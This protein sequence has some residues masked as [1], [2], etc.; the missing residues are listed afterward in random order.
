M[1]KNRYDQAY[2]SFKSLSNS[3]LI[4]IGDRY[5]DKEVMDSALICYTIVSRRYDTHM[6]HED[7]KL[8]A[9]AYMR[10]GNI[11]YIMYNYVQA[12]DM[13][14]QSLEVCKECDLDSIIPRVYNNLGNIYS[15]F[16]DFK[17]AENYYK[18][19][20]KNSQTIDIEGTIYSN[21]RK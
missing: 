16:N 14:L 13:Y 5:Y 19:A 10:L 4:D 17:K 6:P 3:K 9:Y 15:S 7:K 21:Y 1:A 11:H 20:Y 18:Q 2:E 12:Q 8:S